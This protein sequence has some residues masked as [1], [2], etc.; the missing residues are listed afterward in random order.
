MA[1]RV[2]ERSE[3]K[4]KDIPADVGICSVR[5]GDRGPAAGEAMGTWVREQPVILNSPGK[6][7]FPLKQPRF[8]NL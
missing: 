7:A 8:S 2:C 6:R 3:N 4:G 1:L 5:G